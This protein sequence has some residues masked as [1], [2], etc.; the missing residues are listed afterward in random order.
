LIGTNFPNIEK[1]ISNSTASNISV[2]T[3]ATTLQQAVR[4]AEI[5]GREGS[6]LIQL[7]ANSENDANTLVVSAT[8]V[9]TGES[10]SCIAAHIQ[11]EEMSIALNGRYLLDALGA[12]Q[13]DIILA[14]GSKYTP[15]SLRMVDN[16][17]YIAIIMPMTIE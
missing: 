8:S 14:A 4:T 17:E 5:F 10:K 3:N 16:H 2:Q 6:H 13:G 11:G 12:L 1:V 9:E 7:Y 15:I